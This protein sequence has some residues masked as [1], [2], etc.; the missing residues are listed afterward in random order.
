MKKFDLNGFRHLL[1]TYAELRIQENRNRN[2]VITNGKVTKNE[3]TAKSGLSARVF[4]NGIMGFSATVN[5]NEAAVRKVL[6]KA[7][8]NANYLK[9]FTGSLNQG[10]T[11]G[12]HPFNF[13]PFTHVMDLSTKKPI[14]DT[15]QILNFLMTLDHYIA[16]AYPAL[17]SRT[18]RLVELDI[19]KS[20]INTP[21]SK[22]DSLW[23]RSHIYLQLIQ[24]KEG[25]PYSYF[26]V[27]GGTGDFED[28][29]TEPSA[30]YP[31]I[32]NAYKRLMDK[33]EAVEAKAGM[34][35]VIISNEIT[36]IL[37]HE[38]IGHTTE[39]DNVLGGSFI[40]HMVGQQVASDKITLVDFANSYNGKLLPMP[41]FIDDEG[42]KAEDAI[43]IENGILKGFMHNLESAAQ[44]GMKPTGNA[45]AFDFYDE[46]LIR[47]RNTAILPGK[48]KIEDMISSVENGYYIM[49][50]SNGQ[51][52]STGEF[53]FGVHLG[54]EIKNGK[55]GRALKE[56][57]IS[58]MAF[59]VLKS[60]TMLADDLEF[61]V[62]GYCGKKQM[63]PTADGGP[64]LKCRMNIG[65][66]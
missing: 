40:G 60:T 43:I 58:G 63:M 7:K 64:T 22:L 18:V 12:Q 37:A 48:D 31:A 46:P 54:Y 11:R 6:E 5:A 52:D 65:G 16:T 56:T 62:A 59:D 35:D 50:T 28:H 39:A 34:V 10:G 17:N 25:V 20:L 30:L 13:S 32:D 38:A 19:E 47:M 1:P 45:R 8:S 61:F 36:G 9:P 29:F 55:I 49:N 3:V 41:L 2:I 26:E 33:T 24:E 66:N 14:L 21:G 23:T 4:E 15:P 57:T 42:T 44:L 51:A 53:M 27:L